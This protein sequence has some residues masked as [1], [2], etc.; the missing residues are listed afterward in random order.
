MPVRS[1]PSQVPC[2]RPRSTASLGCI[3]KRLGGS[4][5]GWGSW[6]EGIHWAVTF[7]KPPQ[8]SPRATKAQRL[9]SGLCHQNPSFKAPLCSF[10][11]HRGSFRI[12]PRTE[13]LCQG[14]NSLEFLPPNLSD[15]GLPVPHFPHLWNSVNRI[16]LPGRVSINWVKNTENLLTLCGTNLVQHLRWDAVIN[17]TRVKSNKECKAD[18]NTPSMNCSSLC[19]GL[20]FP[21]T[22]LWVLTLWEPLV[23]S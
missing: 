11:C 7:S 6:G 2:S 16:Y 22:P 1:C 10:L 21:S 3:S 12:L 14:C 23:P 4:G 9:W 15:S 8:S 19:F 18:S 17:G 20:W 5:R 13:F